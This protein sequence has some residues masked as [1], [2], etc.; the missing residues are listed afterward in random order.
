MSAEKIL[1]RFHLNRERER[2]AWDVLLRLKQQKGCTYNDVVTSAL[3]AYEQETSG[4]SKEQENR[5]VARIVE[6]VLGAQKQT[7]TASITQLA[8]TQN[9]SATTVIPAQD[10]ENYENVDW[11]FLGG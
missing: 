11:N 8:T 7:I 1:L 3:L 9:S 5:I 4:I 2:Q 10:D 6:A